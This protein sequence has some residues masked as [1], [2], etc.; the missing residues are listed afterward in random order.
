VHGEGIV[1]TTNCKAGGESHS[2]KK[3]LWPKRPCGFESRPRHQTG[4][5]GF[6][7]SM[8]YIEPFS[9]QISDEQLRRNVKEL[10]QCFRLLLRKA[11]S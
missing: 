4:E 7:E 9:F 6:M 2:G 8:D 3:I 11:A 5:K 1:Q 10:G